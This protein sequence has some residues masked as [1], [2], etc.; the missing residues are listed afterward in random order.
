MIIGIPKEIKNHEYRVAATPDMVKSLTTAGHT[1]WVEQDA[2]LA[3]NYSNKQY[4]DAGAVVL[5][6]A[7]EVY[8]AELILKVK[9]VSGYDNIS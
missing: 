5:N 6:S 1:V 9:K 7:K 4:N 8:K 2:G 3:I